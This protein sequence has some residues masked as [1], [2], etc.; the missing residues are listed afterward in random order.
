MAAVGSEAF[1]FES[2]NNSTHRDRGSYPRTLPLWAIV[3]AFVGR[4]P[5][6]CRQIVGYVAPRG[7]G[8]Y[9]PPQAIQYLAQEVVLALW[10]VLPDES[11]VWGGERPLFV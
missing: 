10:G 7:A 5:T 1:S 8:A 2:R 4:G 6:L 11:E 9:N 3:A